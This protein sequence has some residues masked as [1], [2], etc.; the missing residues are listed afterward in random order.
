MRRKLI[1][2]VP[3]GRETPYFKI[4]GTPL[5]KVWAPLFHGYGYYLPPSGNPGADARVDK[6][7][8]KESAENL[9][10]AAIN[11]LLVL[12]LGMWPFLYNVLGAL[13]WTEGESLF[14][15]W[16][17]H[18]TFGSSHT[19]GHTWGF[20]IVSVVRLALKGRFRHW[21]LLL[22]PLLYNTVNGV[23][24]FLRMWSEGDY[25]PVSDSMGDHR[26]D[27]VAHIGGLV[28]GAFTAWWF[29]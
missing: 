25:G 19:M 7:L 6:R 29:T 23:R 1:F 16:D 9:Q 24:N 5:G 3:K 8:A 22:L 28:A 13:L 2:N 17:G 10:Y 21:M 26:V 14:A 12:P 20:A 18:V 4:K 15:Y 11:M 27:N